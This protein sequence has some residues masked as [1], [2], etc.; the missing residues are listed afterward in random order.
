MLKIGYGFMERVKEKTFGSDR[1]LD[2]IS[3]VEEK[4]ISGSWVFSEYYS[5]VP[6]RNV[7]CS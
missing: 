3:G 7:H 6:V 1:I 2:L 5:R 4:K